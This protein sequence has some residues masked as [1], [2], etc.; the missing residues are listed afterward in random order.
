[1]KP[2]ISPLIDPELTSP[3]DPAASTRLRG[4]LGGPV[5]VSLVVLALVAWGR[6]GLKS[7][8]AADLLRLAGRGR[9]PRRGHRPVCC[10]D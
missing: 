4:G 6:P 8:Q 7:H 9:S 2:E 10:G 3:A 5:V 1:M